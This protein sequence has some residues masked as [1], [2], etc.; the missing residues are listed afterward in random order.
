MVQKLQMWNFLDM[1]VKGQDQN[2]WHEQ[3]VWK[4]YL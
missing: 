2:F 4:P 3:K 1:Y